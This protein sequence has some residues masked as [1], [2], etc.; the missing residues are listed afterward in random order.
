[1]YITL[2]SYGMLWLQITNNL[3]SIGLN[4]KEESLS[5]HK[6]MIQNLLIELFNDIMTLKFFSSDCFVILNMSE[7]PKLAPLVLTNGHRP[8]TQSI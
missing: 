5:F 2:V 1:M 6:Q 3:D 7:Y 8:G 4:K